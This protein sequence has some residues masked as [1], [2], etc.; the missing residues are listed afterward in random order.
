MEKELELGERVEDPNLDTDQNPVAKAAA[1]L[2]TPVQR[3]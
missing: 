3:A 1:A 2:L